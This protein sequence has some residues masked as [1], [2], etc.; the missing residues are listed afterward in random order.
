MANRMCELCGKS[1]GHA[2]K[3]EVWGWDVEPKVGKRIFPDG[4][5]G[6]YGELI[7]GDSFSPLRISTNSDGPIKS[8]AVRIEVTGRT[9]TTKYSCRVVRVK[10]I[11]VGDCE[12]DTVSG[13]WMAVP[14]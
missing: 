4:W 7:P 10:V 12:P 11:F 6:W 14:W 1:V 8:L 9:L 13:G 5:N 3:T 2:P